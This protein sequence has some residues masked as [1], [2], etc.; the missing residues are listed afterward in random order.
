MQSAN[1]FFLKHTRRAEVLAV[2][3]VAGWGWSRQSFCI[4]IGEDKIAN[5]I[6]L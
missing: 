4:K 1:Q 5:V 6:Y 2:N 3:G